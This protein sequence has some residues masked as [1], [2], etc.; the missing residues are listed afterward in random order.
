MFLFCKG[1]ALISHR[2]LVFRNPANMLC[3][4]KNSALTNDLTVL[5]FVITSEEKTETLENSTK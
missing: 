2:N 3:Q 4:E 5:F 1:N